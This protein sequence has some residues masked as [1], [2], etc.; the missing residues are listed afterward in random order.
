[1]PEYLETNP[2]VVKVDLS[3]LEDIA[4]G[5]N[6]FIIEMI[7]MFL[8]QTP[9]YFNDIRQGIL[10]KDWKKVSDIAHK[11]KPTLAFMGSNSAKETMAGIEMD[12]RNLVNLD[13]IGATFDA[14]HAYSLNLF[15]QLRIA[16]E[17]LPRD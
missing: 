11:V 4:G 12:S 17:N 3:Y 1:M 5:S 15:A 14:L 16:R 10:D 13:T 9:G 6:D 2:P 7:D 8:E